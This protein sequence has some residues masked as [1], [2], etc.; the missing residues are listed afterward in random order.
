MK[1]VIEF[2]DKGCR[3]VLFSI[4]L[5]R[6]EYEIKLTKKKEKQIKCVA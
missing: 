3:P 1:E 5:N 2:L 6:M 4:Y